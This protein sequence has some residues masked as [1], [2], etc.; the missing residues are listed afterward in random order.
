MPFSFP[1]YPVTYYTITVFNH[2]NGETFTTTKTANFAD[3]S[4]QS[5]SHGDHCYELDFTVIAVNSLGESPPSTIY[6][7]HP[8]GIIP[9]QK[10]VL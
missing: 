3:Y 1:G 2:S 8:I 5:L 7:G 6:T 4:H 9:Y 10:V